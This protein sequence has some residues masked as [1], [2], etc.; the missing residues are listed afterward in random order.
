MNRT[1]EIKIATSN[2][3]GISDRNRFSAFY[4]HM[5]SEKLT[6]LTLQDTHIDGEQAEGLTEHYRN[7]VVVAA[8]GP[9]IQHGVM[10]LID[11]TQAQF[12]GDTEAMNHWEAATG[13][14][15]V[16]RIKTERESFV[17]GCVY[18]PPTRAQR[19]VWG[20]ACLEA[21]RRNVNERLRDFLGGDWNMVTHRE[22]SNAGRETH[23]DDLDLH[24]NILEAIMTPEASY[25]DGWRTRYP[26]QR[27][28]THRNNVGMKIEGVGSSRID[29]IYVRADWYLSTRNWEITP[30]GLTDHRMVSVVYSPNNPLYGKGRWCAPGPMMEAQPLLE[31][32]H[33]ITI[34]TLAAMKSVNTEDK[35][36][37]SRQILDHW[38]A[39]KD[40]FRRTMIARQKELFRHLRSRKHTLTK[41]A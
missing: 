14:I 39:T 24:Q 20:R 34:E 26:D 40:A 31:E 6:V 13:R 10:I 23:S 9:D 36:E 41:Q 33:E 7:L 15:L 3:N 38:K 4:N 22:D 30:V 11:K 8:C 19:S 2:V 21:A 17:V 28:Y 27:V 37:A 5:R 1:P 29:R 35:Q 18:A 32:L 25:V 12:D 16:A